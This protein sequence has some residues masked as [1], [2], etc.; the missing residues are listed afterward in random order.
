MDGLE[1]AEV[2]WKEFFFF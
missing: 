2:V 1:T